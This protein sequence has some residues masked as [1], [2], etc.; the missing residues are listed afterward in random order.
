MAYGYGKYKIPNLR[1]KRK[2]TDTQYY[3]W[4]EL[5]VI[6]LILYALFYAFLVLLIF[7]NSESNKLELSGKEEKNKWKR[8]KQIGKM[9]IVVIIVE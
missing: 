5:L 6:V 8:R 2:E 7:F 3:S 4:E 9:I 1:G